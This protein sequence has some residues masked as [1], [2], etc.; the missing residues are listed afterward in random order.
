MDKPEIQQLILQNAHRRYA[1][2]KYDPNKHIPDDDWQTILEV[3]RLSPSSFGYEPWQFVAL[4]NEAARQAIKPFAWGAANS[5]AGADKL[6]VIL[7]RKNVTYD[8]EYVEHMVNDIKHKDY[9]PTSAVSQNFK[10]FQEDDLGLQTPAD[11]FQ[12]AV[13]QCY[14]AMANM[15]NAAA[16]LDIDSCPIEGFNYAKMNQFMADHHY[17][18]PTMWGVAVMASFGYRNQEITPK[19]RQPLA[20]IYKEIN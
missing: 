4:N 14:I 12:W 9:S 13:R 11:V 7:A 19:V 15:L 18:D 10:T 1:T 17:M 8:S 3:G 2:K 20:D 6:L 16:A 5:I